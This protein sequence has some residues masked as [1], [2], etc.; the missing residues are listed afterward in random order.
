VRAA[1]VTTTPHI[2]VIDLGRMAYRQAYALQARTLEEVVESR[3]SGAPELGRILLVEHDP[4]VTVSARPG[5]GLH[6]VASAGELAAA[7]VAVEETDRGGD[8]TYHGPGQLVVYPIIDLNACGLRLHEY[9]R[10]LEQTIIDTCEIFG[11]AAGRDGCAT[12]VWVGRAEAG[13]NGVAQTCGHT[14]GDASAVAGGRKICAMGLRVRRWVS[15]HG[16]A[17]NVTTNLA[18]FQLIVPCGLAGRQ[19][20]SLRAEL[21]ERCPPM[22]RV[23]DALIEQLRRQLG[24]RFDLKS[25]RALSRAPAPSGAATHARA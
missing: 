8:V 20:T 23:K 13:V 16:L 10:L 12:G 18:H 15:M 7:G 1:N 4:V 9:M 11:V 5:A 3:D 6:V 14:P 19:V 17:L 2:P 22:H 21:G 25:A 24:E